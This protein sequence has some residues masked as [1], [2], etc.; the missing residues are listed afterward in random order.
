VGHTANKRCWAIAAR[1]PGPVLH[2]LQ[3]TAWLL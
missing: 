3:W 1:D 2:G